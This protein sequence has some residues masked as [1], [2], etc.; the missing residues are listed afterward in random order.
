MPA[1]RAG[2]Y[3]P[4]VAFSAPATTG[5]SA[6]LAASVRRQLCRGFQWELPAFVVFCW[7]LGGSSRHGWRA[8]LLDQKTGTAQGSLNPQLYSLAASA[9]TA[10][11]DA[12]ISSSGVAG[13]SVNKASMCNNSIPHGSG[14]GAQ[15][16]FLLATGY[17]EATGLGSVDVSN[18]LSAW[19]TTS[20]AITSPV[21]GS[22]L[23]GASTTFSWT[24]GFNATAYYLWVGT[25]P[26][27]YD[28]VNIGIPTGT[29]AT[30]NLPTTGA[31]IY[32]RLWSVINGTPSQ[33]SDYSYTEF[34][35]TP[36]AITS[37]VNGST[38]TGASTTFSWTAGSGATA[39]YLW[40]GTT[41]GGY[42]LANIGIPTG[43]SATVN[44]PTTGAK[45]YARLWS[46]INGTP[47]Q[48]SDYSYTE[49]HDTPA[50]ITSPVNGSTLTG[51]STTFSW[52]PGSGATAYYLWVGTTPGGYDLVNI[53]IPTGTS[54]TVNLPTTGAK[55]YARLW[56]VI[57]G[58]PSQ[59][60]DYSYTE[61]N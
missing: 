22:T 33:S 19:E 51:A 48:S 5:T 21:N 32:A 24:A 53:G 28:L 10:F 39:Y 17:D 20:A 25:T 42:D 54:A 2:R 30:V 57:N 8:A 43:T 61:S 26:G 52:T 11:H 9:P 1:A 36:A 60:S 35:D 41:P 3:T 15:A 46:V 49:F 58:T 16:G 55:I 23:T 7:D 44:L 37:P 38:L 40:V 47:S 45:I 14:S 31:K 13:C 4:D 50:A 59:S 18:L 29:S 56:S 6:C 34:H 12:T 27:G